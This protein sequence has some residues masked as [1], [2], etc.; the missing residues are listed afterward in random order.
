MNGFVIP[1]QR[2]DQQQLRRSVAPSCRAQRRVADRFK[3]TPLPFQKRHLDDLALSIEFDDH[4]PRFLPRY[5][6]CSLGQT[7]APKLSHSA[8]IVLLR[9]VRVATVFHNG[10]LER[11]AE[12]VLLRRA[13]ILTLRASLSARITRSGQLLLLARNGGRA[14]RPPHKGM[15]E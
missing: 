9:S 10:K 11:Q 12:G 13:R 15:I 3:E 7:F 6:T 14:A 8:R 5:D 1:Q 4:T 2:G